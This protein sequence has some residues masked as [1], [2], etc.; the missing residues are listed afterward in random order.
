VDKPIKKNT[1]LG[2]YLSMAQPPKTLNTQISSIETEKTAEVI[3]RVRLN[4][5]S[6]DLKKTPKEVAV[7]R[8]VAW[9]T[10]RAITTTQP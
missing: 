3:A 2:P 8:R 1:I 9:I 6:M 5:L 7:P 4:S 10:K